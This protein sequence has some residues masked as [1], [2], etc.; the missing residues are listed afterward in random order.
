MKSFLSRLPH[1]SVLSLLIFHA[2][3]VTSLPAAVRRQTSPVTPQELLVAFEQFLASIPLGILNETDVLL[4]LPNGEYTITQK[5]TDPVLRAAQIATTRATFLYGPPVAGGP[6][7]PTGS[8]G[9]DRVALDQ[10]FIQLDL[11]PELA[12]AVM[13]LGQAAADVAKV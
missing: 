4:P 3:H 8:Y 10:A 6:Y 7:F 2:I 11:V 5:A 9:S 12:L 13:D 1:W